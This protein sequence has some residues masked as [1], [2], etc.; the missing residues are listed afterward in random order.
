MAGPGLHLTLGPLL[1]SLSLARALCLCGAHHRTWGSLGEAWGLRW[2]HRVPLLG[3]CPLPFFGGVWEVL[4][5]LN[6]DSAAAKESW[7]S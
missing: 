1:P 5:S 4:A 2:G 6:E 3:Q 7:R